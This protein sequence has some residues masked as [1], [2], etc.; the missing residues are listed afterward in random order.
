MARIPIIEGSVFKSKSGEIYRVFECL[1]FG[2]GYWVVAESD[3]SQT[4]FQR[5]QLERM[6]RVAE[7]VK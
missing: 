3:R 2:R 4:V 6:E 5:Q 1:G 7:P